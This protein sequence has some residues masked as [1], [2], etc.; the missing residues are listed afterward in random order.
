MQRLTLMLKRLV[1]KDVRDLVRLEV[2]NKDLSVKDN[3]FVLTYLVSNDIE[4]LAKAARERA[5]EKEEVDK[6]KEEE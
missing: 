3:D 6:D 2:L 4:G 1:S 5:K